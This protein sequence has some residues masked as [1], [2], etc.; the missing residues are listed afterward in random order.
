M[1]L[2]GREWLEVKL[3]SLGYWFIKTTF[4]LLRNNKMRAM[5]L[6]PSFLI[7]IS[8]FDIVYVRLIDS[9]LSFRVALIQMTNNLSFLFTFTSLNICTHATCQRY[10]IYKLL[11]NAQRSP[12]VDGYYSED[13][14]KFRIKPFR[15]NFWKKLFYASSSTCLHSTIFC[16]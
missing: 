11:N 3:S 5:Y 1:K 6:Y 12:K 15:N 9:N 2:T 10:I 13:P 14:S 16:E 4:R 8:Y 7:Y